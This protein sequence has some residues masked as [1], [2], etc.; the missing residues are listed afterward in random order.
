MRFVL[1]RIIRYRRKVVQQNIDNAFPDKTYA[2]KKKIIK[3]FY[4]NLCDI[5]VEGIK[6][7]AMNNKQLKQRYSFKNSEILNSYFNKKQ[8][9][10]AVGSHYA[11][12]EWGIMAAPLQ[13]QHKLIAFYTPLTNPFIDRYVK[14][15]RDKFGTRLVSTTEVRRAFSNQDSTPAIWFFGA[16]Q[17]PSNIK[18]VHWLTFLNQDTACNKGPE[19]FSRLYDLPVIYFDV[20]RVKKGY[21]EVEVIVLEEHSKSTKNGDIT[22]KYYGTLESIINRNPAHYLWS[23]RRWKHKRKEQ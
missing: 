22:E 8:S 3:E 21:Y 18:G 1:Y 13:L 11:N 2:E 9:L 19:F 12:W 20:Q 23:H 14:R 5:F 10:I 7:F 17:S 16:D 15:N 4:H 6:G